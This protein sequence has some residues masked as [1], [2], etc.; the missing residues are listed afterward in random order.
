M[1]EREEEGEDFV[2]EDESFLLQIDSIVQNYQVSKTAASQSQKK[3]SAG[4]LAGR[5]EPGPVGVFA[6]RNDDGLRGRAALPGVAQVQNTTR[7]QRHEKG[8]RFQKQWGAPYTRDQE[9]SN[10]RTYPRPRSHDATRFFRFIDRKGKKNVNKECALETRHESLSPIGLGLEVEEP[11]GAAAAAAAPEAVCASVLKAEDQTC[12]LKVSLD[13]VAAEKW[14]L[15]NTPRARKYQQDIAGTCLFTNTLVCLPTGLGKT[16][17]AAIVMANYRR[18]FPEG[19]I[20][21]TAPTRPL[22]TQQ[23]EA[24]RTLM[25]IPKECTVELTGR[26]SV[27]ERELA[28]QKS[29]IFFAT[30]QI[31]QNDILRGLCPKR[32]I[33]CLVMDECHRAVGRHAYAAISQHLHKENVVHRCLGLSATPG[34]DRE[35]LQEVVRN[36]RISKIEFRSE[37]DPDIKEFVHQRHIEKIIVSSTNDARHACCQ[38]LEAVLSRLLCELCSLGGYW[39]SDVSKTTR[40]AI[41]QAMQSFKANPMGTLQNLHRSPSKSQLGDEERM[42]AIELLFEQLVPLYSAREQIQRYGVVQAWDYLSIQ[43]GKATC[44]FQ[45][46]KETDSEFCRFLSKL[47]HLARRRADDPKIE[48]LR[49]ILTRHFLPP[50]SESERP[51]NVIVFTNLREK[52]QEV[53]TSLQESDSKESPSPLKPAA[54]IG[55][56]QRRGKGAGMNQKTQQKVLKQFRTGDVNILVATCVAEEGLDIPEVSLIVC[57]DPSVSPGRNIQRMGRTGRKEEGKVIYLLN[58]GKENDDYNHS[59]ESAKKIHSA[60]RSDGHYLSLSP[61]SRMIPHRLRPKPTLMED[62]GGVASLGRVKEWTVPDD[63]R[64]EEGRR[65]SNP[66]LLALEKRKRRKM[67]MVEQDQECPAAAADLFDPA[68]AGGGGEGKC[69]VKVKEREKSTFDHRLLYADNSEII[70]W[71]SSGSVCIKAFPA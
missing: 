12:G 67:G 40:N 4:L 34:A 27:E 11:N 65:R 1:A 13:D 32:K 62:T 54:F 47:Q 24:C 9:Y 61:S 10:P 25:Q 3:K 28:W 44:E 17:V 21:F 52:V 46:L 41:L 58:E 14:L 30:P 8:F 39:T 37:S 20:I 26:K 5:W 6:E 60:L 31:V 70:S 22:V 69:G 29:A 33:V 68:A 51:G 36:L 66:L 71:D 53:V 57:Y 35:R 64:A 56:S 7:E 19:I 23:I 43:M 18:W 50:P 42:A 63:K 2:Y 15:P 16:M 55:Q 49:K 59:I 48:C 45:K 38:E